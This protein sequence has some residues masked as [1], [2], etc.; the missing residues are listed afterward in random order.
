[1]RRSRQ[2]TS[3]HEAGSGPEDCPVSHRRVRFIHGSRVARCASSRRWMPALRLRYRT[4][5]N[6]EVLWARTGG[7][8]P[9]QMWY[10]LYRVHQP[11]VRE[12]HAQTSERSNYAHT[13]R[14]D[15]GSWPRPPS[16]E[17]AITAIVSAARHRCG[18]RPAAPGNWRAAW[19]RGVAA[20][21]R[22]VVPLPNLRFTAGLD[23]SR[24]ARREVR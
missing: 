24:T 11:M 14:W 22:G 17:G 20:G 2:V 18:C 3:G 5:G 4:T 23:R 13:R 16:R 12:T 10:A 1:M 6:T 21:R 19:V 8:R 15:K 9:V 7:T